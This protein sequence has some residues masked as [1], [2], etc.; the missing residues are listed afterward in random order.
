MGHEVAAGHALENV[1]QVG[2]GL[3]VVELCCRD[4][5]CDDG[6]P[7]GAAT[8]T[9]A[10]AL[11]CSPASTLQSTQHSDAELKPAA[12]QSTAA[13]TTIASRRRMILTSSIS[14]KHVC[15][16]L[17]VIPRGHR[18]IRVLLQDTLFAGCLEFGVGVPGALPES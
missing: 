12:P 17:P 16:L 13:S 14:S 8:G 6:P 3:D 9:T 11:T 4:E 10:T 18:I 2:V 1:L 5:G 7:V 15:L